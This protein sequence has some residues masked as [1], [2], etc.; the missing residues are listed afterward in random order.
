MKSF[1]DFVSLDE[2]LITFGGK[3]Y[4]KF[5]QVVILAG[6]AGSGKGFTL[7]KLLGIEGITLDVD[8]LKKLVMGS[9]K[10]AAEIKAKTGHDVKT[11]N[12]KNPDNVATLHHVIADVFNVSNKNQ[13]RVYAGIAAA[14][15]DRK[16]NLIFDVTLKSMSKLANIARDVEALGYQKEN[17]HIVWVMNDVHIAMQQNLKRD[18]VVPKEILM[19]THEGAALTMAKILNMGDSLKQY[20]DGDIW[21]SFNKVGIDSEIKKSEKGGMFVV[22]SNYIKVKAKGKPQKSIDQLD[23]ELVAKVAAYAP[24][25][26][27]WG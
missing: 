26:D 9:T 19:D 14:P 13:A 27:T 1:K 15:E 5:G 18:R 25:T 20:M 3:A 23:K 6:G 7:E 24:K 17:I 4:P 2:A 22:K 12:L 11:M 10:L 8:A 16:P 21:I